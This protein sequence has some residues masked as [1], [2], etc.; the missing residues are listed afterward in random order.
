MDRE[1]YHGEED[2]GEEAVHQKE[3]GGRVAQEAQNDKSVGEAVDQEEV[4]PQEGGPEASFGVAARS[5]F[6][7]GCRTGADA[8]VEPAERLRWWW[9]QRR[10]IATEQQQNAAAPSAAACIA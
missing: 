2:K 1:V 5:A 10:L 7:A 3:E 4:C 9:R 8:I 6:D